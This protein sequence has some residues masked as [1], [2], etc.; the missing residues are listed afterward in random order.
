VGRS[1]GRVCRRRL[2]EHLLARCAAA[3][4]RYLEGEVA[5][6]AAEPDGARATLTC[7][8][9]TAVRTK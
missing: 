7:R 5:A 8:D 6:V 2:R 9:G 3:G 1:Y 4:V